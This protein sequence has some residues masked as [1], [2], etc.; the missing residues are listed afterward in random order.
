MEIKYFGK[1]NGGGNASPLVT[2][3]GYLL[4]LT[5]LAS[6]CTIAY[7][8]GYYKR[9]QYKITGQQMPVTEHPDYWAVRG[10]A[11]TVKKLHLTVDAAF[12]GNSITCGSSFE[13]YFAADSLNIINLGYPGDNIQ[14]MLNRIDM[15]VS[16]HPKK[17]F[18]MAGINGLKEQT[19]D[20]FR[21][22]YGILITAIKD[23]LPDAKIYLE[24]ILP[25]NTE[26]RLGKNIADNKKIIEAN[27]LIGVIARE[28][29]CAYVDLHRLY[30]KNGEMPE[31]LTRDGVHL[32]PECYDRWAKAIHKY[33]LE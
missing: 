9:I 14:G 1:S 17:V 25:V 11:N 6:A 15:L 19:L 32:K 12:F 27:K 23:S 16:V 8:S 3:F 20:E 30:V 26:M 24:S 5:F 4:A 22:E 29:H 21:K 2:L 13:E 31:A 10:W 7:K 33:L 18:V 28:R